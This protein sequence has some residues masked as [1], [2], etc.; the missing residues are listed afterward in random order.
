MFPLLAQ[1][2]AKEQ[3]QTNDDSHKRN[4]AVSRMAMALRRILKRIDRWFS[5]YRLQRFF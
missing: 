1:E 5:D 2:T 4:V 3:I